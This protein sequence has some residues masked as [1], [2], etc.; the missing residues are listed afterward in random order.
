VTDQTI[1]DAVYS[2]ATAKALADAGDDA[3]A[4]AA[5]VT[6]G[7]PP[8]DVVPTILTEGGVMT[9][10]GPTLGDQ[11]L[12]A[13]EAAAGASGPY[14][15]LLTRI[16]RLLRVGYPSGVDFGNDDVRSMLDTLQA[17]AIL[18]AQAVRQLKAAAERPASISASDVSR[19]WA[20]YRP[21]GQITGQ[22]S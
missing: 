18:P 8:P 7:A 15:S 17:A 10:L 13:I 20:Q 3:G 19:V 1:H 22:P 5:V 9:V 16:I 2:N 4:A 14:A 12:S 21:N 11:S 6:S